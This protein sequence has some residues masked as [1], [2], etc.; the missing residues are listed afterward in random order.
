MLHTQ[1]HDVVFFRSND[2]TAYGIGQ[3]AHQ[4]ATKEGTEV[5]ALVYIHGLLRVQRLSCHRKKNRYQE[6]QQRQ[7]IVQ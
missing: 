7:K 3:T 4:I 6:T 2:G 1:P 5:T